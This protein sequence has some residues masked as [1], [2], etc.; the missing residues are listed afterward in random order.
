MRTSWGGHAVEARRR[1]LPAV[2]ASNA[3]V[4][5]ASGFFAGALTLATV[6]AARTRLRRRRSRGRARGELERRSVV[7]TR[8]FLVDVH[9]LGR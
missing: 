8:S 6:R 2:P 7:A 1:L 9:L 3:T 5:V 4:A